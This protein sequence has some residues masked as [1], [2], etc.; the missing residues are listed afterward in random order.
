MHPYTVDKMSLKPSSS[1]PST[2]SKSRIR[3]PP[4]VGID[5]G[6]LV[7]KVLT[8][9]RKSPVHPSLTLD[10]ADHTTI[11][12]LVDGYDPHPNHRGI[13]KKLEMNAASDSIFNP[14]NGHLVTDLTIRDCAFVTLSD[15]AFDL[16]QRGAEWRQHH[17]GI[18]FKFSE[19][20]LWHCVWATLAEHDEKLGTCVF[21]SYNDVFLR[22]IQRPNPKHHSPK[23]SR[24]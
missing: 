11:Q 16:K 14:A 23:K 24:K 9:T 6:T 18:A 2:P 12:V 1:T 15:R 4:I 10:F 8:G 22:N 13:P 19:E 21:R 3:A 7:G 20:S 17:R 5:P